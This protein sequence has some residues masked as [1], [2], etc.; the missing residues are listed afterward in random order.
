MGRTASVE[1]NIPF[2][3]Y[4]PEKLKVRFEKMAAQND[5]TLSAEGRVMI[6]EYLK[7]MK[8]KAS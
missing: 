8:T 3:I 2:Y 5:R 6:E 7:M 1:K 4:I